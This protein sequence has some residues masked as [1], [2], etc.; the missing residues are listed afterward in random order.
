MDNVSKKKLKQQEKEAAEKAAREYAA[1]KNPTAAAE[2]TAERPLS[3]DPE[4]PYCRG[5]AYKA[6][7]YRKGASAEESEE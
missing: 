7:R 2:E 5:R 3:G 4:R 1:K 6:D